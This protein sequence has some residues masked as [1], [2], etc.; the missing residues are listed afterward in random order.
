MNPSCS[1]IHVLMLVQDIGQAYTKANVI[2]RLYVSIP[3]D[4]CQNPQSVQYSC[5]LDIYFYHYNQPMYII[6]YVASIIYDTEKHFQLITDKKNN[7]FYHVLKNNTRQRGNQ[8][9][10]QNTIENEIGN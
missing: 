10:R 6:K 7:Y 9:K 2:C 4:S 8:T 1:P 3:E 5:P